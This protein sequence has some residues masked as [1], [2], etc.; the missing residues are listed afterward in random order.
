MKSAMMSATVVLC[1]VLA[2]QINAGEDDS[3][4]AVRALK[5][6]SLVVRAAAKAKQPSA[7]TV[8]CAR[9][10]R[11]QDAIDRYPSPVTIDV[12]GICVEDVLVD[13]KD[14][15]LR[16]VDPAADGIRGVSSNNAALRFR[17]SSSS[18]ENLGISRG[19]GSGVNISFS[20]MFI[21]GCQMI[22]NAFSGLVVDAGSRVQA[23]EAVLSEN[24]RG[25]TVGIGATFF[26]TGCRLENNTRFAGLANGGIFSLL[27]SVVLG[28]HGIAAVGGG[29]YAD[30][31]CLSVDTA[32]PCS[33]NVTG[34]AA[35]AFERGTAAIWGVPD[36]TGQVNA[37][38]AAMVSLYGSTQL[39]AGAPGQ[40]PPRNSVTRFGRLTVDPSYD[41][42]LQNSRVLGTDVTHFGSL[43]V[44]D[45][46]AL[47][48]PV[49]C[50]SGGDA[51]LDPTITV[52]PAASAS[53]CEHAVVPAAP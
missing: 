46:A 18:I 17:R 16:G 23:V 48:G 34:S 45:V 29:A 38:D 42:G 43:I 22:G 19:P 30:I 1:S 37:T 32:H 15:A 47:A 10:E 8:D 2:V 25:V 24:V 40:G 31:D 28:R 50:E 52:E 11:I 44:A 5:R 20:T 36:F 4:R 13:G 12:R 3:G 9:G 6:E 39:A 49:R 53:G 51:W 33:M 21:G 26:C 35:S 14:V 27:N 7:A 41:F